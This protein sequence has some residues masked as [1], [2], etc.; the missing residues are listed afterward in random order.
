MH[1]YGKSAPFPSISSAV[2]NSIFARSAASWHTFVSLTGFR[3]DK[4]IWDN[5]KC[6]PPFPEIYLIPMIHF[7]AWLFTIL[8][9]KIRSENLL[10]QWIRKLT[11][12]FTC[13]SFKRL[14]TFAFDFFISGWIIQFN[15][16]TI[17]FTRLTRTSLAWISLIKVES[18]FTQ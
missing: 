9:R 11:P 16:N 4:P 12:S 17:I 6:S 18:T 3:H 14:W 10:I 2:R 5:L 7:Q 8:K 13:L 1:P 15:T